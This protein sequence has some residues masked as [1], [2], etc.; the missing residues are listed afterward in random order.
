MNLLR[1]IKSANFS[2]DEIK[3]LIQAAESIKASSH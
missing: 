3:N 2:Q 1:Y